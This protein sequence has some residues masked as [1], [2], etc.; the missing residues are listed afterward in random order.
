LPANLAAAGYALGDIDL[1]LLTHAH[2]D[3]AATDKTL[4]DG[5]HFPF[6]G[7]GHVLREGNSY[8]WLPADW[9]WTS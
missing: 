8:R 2:S 3:R 1:I 5:Y 9:Q 4:V 7:F 6:P